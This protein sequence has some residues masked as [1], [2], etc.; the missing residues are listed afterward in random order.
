[1]Y[2]F[3]SD[4]HLGLNGY[5]IGSES[6]SRERLLISWLDRVSADAEAIIFVG[7]L[8][9][10]WFEYK[11]VIP[12]GFSRLLGKLSELTDRGIAVHLF[13]GN[14][15]MWAF[16]YLSSECG[17]ILHHKEAVMDLDGRRV[18][19][20]HGDNLANK[21]PMV[22]VMNSAFRSKTVQWAFSNLMHPDLALRFGQWWSGSSRQSKSIKHTFR[23]EKE[24][25]VAYAREYAEQHQDVDYFIFGHIHCAEN[26]DIGNG[27][28]AMFLGEW[29]ENPVYGIVSADKFELRKV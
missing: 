23:D 18:F 19:V 15:D 12:K 16:D 1:M 20:A 4:V 13:L 8:F 28:R 3:A 25:L 5:G 7:D 26:Y 22:R 2:Y 21:P 27:R 17:V 9:D 11:R 14:H 24:P 29:I 10:F 6:L